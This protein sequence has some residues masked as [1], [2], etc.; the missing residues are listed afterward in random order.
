MVEPKRLWV[1]DGA[2][3]LFPGYLEQLEEAAKEAV[4]YLLRTP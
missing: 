4:G 1:I 3:H 2:T